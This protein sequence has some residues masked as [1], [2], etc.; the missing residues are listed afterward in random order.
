MNKIIIMICFLTI[1][2]CVH[3][4]FIESDKKPLS[5]EY[6]KLQNEGFRAHFKDY[7]YKSQNGDKLKGIIFNG[8]KFPII[9]VQ[10]KL[11]GYYY[12]TVDG[13]SIVSNLSVDCINPKLKF[14][15]NYDEMTNFPRDSIMVTIKDSAYIYCYS[16]LNPKII[17]DKTKNTVLFN[18]ENG[19]FYSNYKD[20]WYWKLDSSKNI[21][22]KW[23]Y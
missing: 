2:S 17:Q 1:T 15:D 21:V 3:Y 16:G 8:Q 18:S 6:K 12:I 14:I 7:H 23:F 10:N 22:K 13:N 11:D 9:L 20:G 19:K 5:Q 4:Q